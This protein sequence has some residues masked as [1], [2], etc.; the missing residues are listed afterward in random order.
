MLK[1]KIEDGKILIID[2]E[3]G[4]VRIFMRV[5]KGAGFN[6]VISITDPLMAVET[7]QSFRPDLILLDLKMPKLDGFG[8]MA[9]LKEVETK[10]YLPILVLTAQR[11]DSARLLALESGAKDFISKPFEMTEALTRVRN[12]LEVRLLHNE[13]RDNNVE[14]EYRV[15]KRTQE[16]EESRMD[17]I[18]RLVRASE[19]RGNATNMHGIRVSHFCSILA[20]ELGMPHE[21]TNLLHLASPLHDI[22]HVGIPDEILSKKG[23][24]SAN[25]WKIVK[26]SPI[27][28][29]E[30]LSG[31]DSKLLQL[32][33]SICKSHEE[34]W[35]GSGYPCGLKG[36]EIPIEGRVVAVCDKFDQMIN[37][38]FLNSTSYSIEEAIQKVEQKSGIEFDPE[39]VAAFKRALPDIKEAAEQFSEQ[40]PATVLDHFRPAPN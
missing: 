11:D 36:E 5:L 30:I 25:E 14:L 1:N 32:A 40:D 15:K 24:L 10:S 13:V 17:I 23:E 9:A 8:V 21:Q 27:V 33:E 34:R 20:E 7:Y 2:D 12:M 31:S 37:P 19:F 3:P 4:N 16:L 35:D 26:L 29:A 22:G 6:N 39:V 38:G 28:G 18:H